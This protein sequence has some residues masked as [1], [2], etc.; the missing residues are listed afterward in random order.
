MRI[1]PL[2][3]CRHSSTKA[4]LDCRWQQL[5]QNVVCLLLCWAVPDEVRSR[6][7]SHE[8]KC[9]RSWTLGQFFRTCSGCSEHAIPPRCLRKSA[10]LVQIS[11][12]AKSK[13]CFPILMLSCSDAGA[14]KLLWKRTCFMRIYAS[15]HATASA[16]C[17]ILNDWSFIDSTLKYFSP[18]KLLALSYTLILIG[19]L[20]TIAYH[21]WQAG[22]AYNEFPRHK[23]R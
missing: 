8:A 7:G 9:R 11:A 18:N 17:C 6:S 15:A 20:Y 23:V 4:P 22:N 14:V 2:L 10:S 5:L 19:P 12:K 3:L 1:V 21:M 13:T 16:S